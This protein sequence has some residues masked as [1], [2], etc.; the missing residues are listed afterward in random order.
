MFIYTQA[1]HFCKGGP[2]RYAVISHSSDWLQ[3]Y[4][5][6]L[7][8]QVTLQDMLGRPPKKMYANVQF[9]GPSGCRVIYD[10]LLLLLLLL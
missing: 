1:T 5:F 8:L 10:I 2:F 9:H 6:F 3:V 4:M 7:S